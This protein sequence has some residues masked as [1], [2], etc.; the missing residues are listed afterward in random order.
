MNE[1]LETIFRKVLE[2]DELV[3]RDDLTAHD[4][5]NWDSL[6]HINL[7][8]RIEDAFGVKFNITEVNELRCVGDIISLLRKKGVS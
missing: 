1:K 6:A 5:E 7:I 3:L 4:V 2:D 8:L